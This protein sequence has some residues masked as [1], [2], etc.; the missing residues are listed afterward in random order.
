MIVE[1]AMYGDRCRDGHGLHILTM[2]VP[3]E[4]DVQPL[5]LKSCCRTFTTS[6]GAGERQRAGMS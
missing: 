2:P 5:T 4:E 1:A 3:K 6:E